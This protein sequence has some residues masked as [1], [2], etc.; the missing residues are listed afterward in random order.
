M[1]FR[2]LLHR[3]GVT[4]GV[5]VGGWDTVRVNL[6]QC[7]DVVEYQLL[8]FLVAETDAGVVLRQNLGLGLESYCSRVVR[9]PGL[10]QGRAD[11]LLER[12]LRQTFGYLVG[13]NRPA[14]QSGRSLTGVP[15][16]FIK[17]LASFLGGETGTADDDAGVAVVL[18][19]RAQ[20]LREF[21]KRPVGC[22][23]TAT[24]ASSM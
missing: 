8:C 22:W 12:V 6:F 24:M 2:Y 5:F 19:G 20:V 15:E 7:P 10:L 17:S 16:L 3:R 13:V 21:T 9:V 11:L 23:R 1:S 18:R 14:T 4:L